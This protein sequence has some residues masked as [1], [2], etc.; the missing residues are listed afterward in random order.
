MEPGTRQALIET[1]TRLV[2]KRGYSACSYAD[3][4]EVVGIRKPSIHHHF[5]SKEDLGE[6]IVEVYAAEFGK[7][8]DQIHARTPD[9]IERLKR[10]AGL[11]KDGLSR[12]E[13]C[14]CGV[15]AS[16]ISI[17]PSRVQTQVR[18]FFALNLR[19][20]EA[21]LRDGVA[22]GDLRPG[23][24]PAREAHTILSALQGATFVALSMHQPAS[25][26]QAL[27]GLLAGLRAPARR[28]R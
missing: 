3:L 14:L 15:L 4:A 11:Y 22:R 2:R 7:L 26:D 13:G 20:L 12:G 21:T 6:A 9:P 23:L 5:P 28:T 17:L 27:A 19:W 24:S 16:E 1:A 18:R 8:L 25:F 10:Y